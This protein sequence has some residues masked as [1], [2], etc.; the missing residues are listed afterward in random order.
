MLDS[1]K[2][3]RKFRFEEYQALLNL[4]CGVD[5]QLG[6]AGVNMASNRKYSEYAIELHGLE[7][8]E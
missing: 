6:Q 7:L 1:I 2:Q 4:Q 5:Q 8:H 3:T